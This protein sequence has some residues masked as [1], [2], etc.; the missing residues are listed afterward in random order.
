MEHRLRALL[1]VLL[2][3]LLALPSIAALQPAPSTS[4][5]HAG[6]RYSIRVEWGASAEGSLLRGTIFAAGRQAAWEQHASIQPLVGEEIAAL[7]VES[8]WVSQTPLG[9]QLRLELGTVR[10]GGGVLELQFAP[11]AIVQR[12]KFH[13]IF[14]TNVTH[15]TSLEWS[16]PFGTHGAASSSGG[17]SI[18][19]ASALD[20]P[21]EGAYG[22]FHADSGGAMVGEARLS[23]LFFLERPTRVGV[24]SDSSAWATPYVGDPGDLPS[25]GQDTMTWATTAIAFLPEGSTPGAFLR[26]LATPQTGARPHEGDLSATP[27]AVI[28]VADRGINPYHVDFRAPGLVAHPSTY[29]SGFPAATPALRLTFDADYDA[30]RAADDALWSGVVPGQLYWIP[31]T[32]I[33]GAIGMPEEVASN[34]PEGRLILDEAGHGTKAASVA[35]GYAHGTCPRCLLVAIEGHDEAI[36]WAAR[37]PWIDV[38][39]LSWGALG[40]LPLGS[41]DVHTSA[42]HAAGKSVLA[43]AGNGLSGTALVPDRNPSVT[44]PTSGPSWVLAVGSASEVNQR[45]ES[46]HGV[47]V[48]VVAYTDLQAASGASVGSS[49]VF[50][51]TSCSTPVAAGLLAALLLEAREILAD[52]DEGTSVGNVASAPQAPLPASGPLVDGVLSLDELERTFT[53]TARATRAE[54]SPIDPNTQPPTPAS[55]VSEG[56]GLVTWE[57]VLE[58][59]RVLRGESPMPE[60]SAEETYERAVDFARDALWTQARAR[61][62]ASHP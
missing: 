20:P 34:E 26:W 54:P 51:G 23:E 48:D 2:V 30:A 19:D 45:D 31:G 49:E 29:L 53:R 59:A 52:F 14:G 5:L 3:V 39:T 35:A 11:D 4:F 60:R 44:R 10:E 62:A 61:A 17:L 36:E 22:V 21:R 57:S 1:P 27:I 15:A 24:D 6:D 28:A 12:S 33:V 46:W 42:A 55:F 40:S 7:R 56:Y 9:P 32:K 41:S 43:S 8:A 16:T 38:I 58:G 50:T 47:P 25:T 37:Q 13:A 18:G